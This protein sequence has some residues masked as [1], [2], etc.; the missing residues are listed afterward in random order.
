M[1][2]KKSVGN[3]PQGCEIYIFADN[4]IEVALVMKCYC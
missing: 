4:L 2:N 3:R 1:S